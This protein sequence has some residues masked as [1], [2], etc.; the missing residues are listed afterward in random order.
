MCTSWTCVNSDDSDCVSC[1]SVDL[2]DSPTGSAPSSTP[3]LGAS[4]GQ[5]LVDCGSEQPQ[6]T[7]GAPGGGIPLQEIDPLPKQTELQEFQQRHRRLL[8]NCRNSV[9]V[10]DGPGRRYFVGIIDVFTVYGLKKRLENIWKTIRFPG[11]AFSTVSPPTYSGRFC[12]WIEQ[13]TR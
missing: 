5:A 12:Q 7:A 3:L 4:A 1:R 9:H 6:G 10:I 2:P 8:P 13:R 11:R